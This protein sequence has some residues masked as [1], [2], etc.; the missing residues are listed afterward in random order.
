MVCIGQT[1]AVLFVLK[2]KSLVDTMRSI[3]WRNNFKEFDELSVLSF[4]AILFYS[5]ALERYS[6]TQRDEIQRCEEAYIVAIMWSRWLFL[7]LW[8]PPRT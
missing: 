7:F 6:V 2:L 8:I 5:K 3:R 4:S 1:N